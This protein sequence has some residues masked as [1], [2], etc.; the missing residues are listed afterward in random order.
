MASPAEAEAQMAELLQLAAFDPE[1][2]AME[3]MS[4]A[5]DQELPVT[6]GN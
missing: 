4:L 6:E 1:P 2:P 5:V 3:E